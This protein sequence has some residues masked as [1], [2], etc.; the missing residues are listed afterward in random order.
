MQLTCRG[1][2]YLSI[3]SDSGLF[4]GKPFTEC[5]VAGKRNRGRQSCSDPGI[6]SQVDS[7]CRSGTKGGE[8]HESG[9][10]LGG[11]DCRL[12][13]QHD[14]YAVSYRIDSPTL[15]ALKTIAVVF[16]NQRLLTHRTDQNF[17]QFLVDHARDFTPSKFRGKGQRQ[18]M[19][20]F[21]FQRPISIELP[22]LYSGIGN[23]KS[24]IAWA[25]P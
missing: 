4:S 17:Q 8:W 5:E 16:K 18:Q 7:L 24:K 19:R 10:H 1:R 20:I 15:A 12:V 21:N 25:W 23:R 14:G 11:I 6:F 22:D 2:S 3:F 13:H 9:G